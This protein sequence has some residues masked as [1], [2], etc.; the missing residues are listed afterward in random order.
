MLVNVIVLISAYKSCHC[1]VQVCP[2]KV[3]MA[4]HIIDQRI[5]MYFN[6]GLTQAELHCSFLLERAFR[7]VL[8]I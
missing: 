6:Q 3:K 4:D 5:R 7:L 2:R 1:R 8:I